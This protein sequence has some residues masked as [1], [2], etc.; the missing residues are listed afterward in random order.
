[1]AGLTQGSNV[2]PKGNYS[3]F[4]AYVRNWTK[5]VQIISDL[6]AHASVAF[7]SGYALRE[8][9]ESAGRRGGSLTKMTVRECLSN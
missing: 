2:K 5:A 4:S 3:T 6:T 8:T 7:N 9:G 1:M